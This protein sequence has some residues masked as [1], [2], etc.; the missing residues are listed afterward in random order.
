MGQSAL[1]TNYLIN[2]KYD[3]IVLHQKFIAQ[4]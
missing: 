3:F 4:L 1:F 2:K